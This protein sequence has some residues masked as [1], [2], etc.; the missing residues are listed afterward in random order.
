[1]FVHA[2]FITICDRLSSAVGSS[3]K[4]YTVF[5]LCFLAVC[6]TLLRAPGLSD[7]LNVFDSCHSQICRHG[8]MC[9]FRMK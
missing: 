3:Y 4:G 8:D 6:D 5:V 2:L 7:D 9:V 1:M